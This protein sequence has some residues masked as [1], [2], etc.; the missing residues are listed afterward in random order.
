VGVEVSDRVGGPR[1]I[2]RI[3]EGAGG[4]VCGHG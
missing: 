4:V 2:G 3:G 1:G